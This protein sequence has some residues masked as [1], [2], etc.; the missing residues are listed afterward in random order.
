MFHFNIFTALFF[1][2][3]TPWHTSGVLLSMIMTLVCLARLYKPSAGLL[4]F[5]AR[6]GWQRCEVTEVTRRRDRGSL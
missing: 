2:F 4:L 1:S 6:A 3:H 5:T